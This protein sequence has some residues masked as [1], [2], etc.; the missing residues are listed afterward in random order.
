MQMA[1]MALVSRC[2]TV[3]W[4]VWTAGF[5]KSCQ[6]RAPSA[7]DGPGVLR[8]SVWCGAAKRRLE[9]KRVSDPRPLRERAFALAKG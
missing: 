3:A 1:V 8:F 7:P 6:A 4:A 2:S 5:S 9:Q